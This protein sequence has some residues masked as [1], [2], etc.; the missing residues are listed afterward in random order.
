MV[1]DCLSYNGEKDILDLRLNILKP[2]VD[3]FIIVEAP[4]TF[5][6][7]PKPL[8]GTNLPWDYPDFPIKYC[9]IDENYTDEEML[10]AYSSPNT[11]GA[12]HWKREFLQK[13]SIKKALTHLNDEDIVYISD[14]DEIW[15]PGKE[16][17]D[18][19][20]KLK[21]LV[22][23]Y[24]LNNRSDEPWAGTFVAKYKNIKNECLNHLRANATM[25]LNQPESWRNVIED[26]GWHF[27]SM[28][29][30]EEFK[31]K[32]SSSYSEEDYWSTPI[33]ATLEENYKN[34]KD[35]LN[36]SNRKFTF[37]EDESDW[38]QYLKENKEKYI[39]L[40]SKAPSS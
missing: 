15:K 25:W 35:W 9:V 2:Y 36:F 40:I 27:T 19:V 23:A 26:G 17:G 33:Q 12:E 37:W 6:N 14:C 22:Y 7:K 24:H 31:R 1:V 30:F 11:K 16:I 39:H 8:Y 13:E 38:P 32:L 21:Q 10:E 29:G 28:G 3:Q 5:S 18:K 20:Y 4:T 34:N